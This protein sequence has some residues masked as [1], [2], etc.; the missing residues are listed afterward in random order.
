MS[1][2]RIPWSN[3]KGKPVKVTIEDVFLLA[4]PRGDRE[5]S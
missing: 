3:L 5:V 1:M 2:V 4:A